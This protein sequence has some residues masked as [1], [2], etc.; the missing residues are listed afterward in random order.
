[1][2]T[3]WSLKEVTEGWSKWQI[4]LCVGAPIALGV[5]GIFLYRRSKSKKTADNRGSGD[6]KLPG[7]K[8]EVAEPKVR[9]AGS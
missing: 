3:H 9:C 5:A 4:A 2:A 8:T 6:S 7:N 1:M